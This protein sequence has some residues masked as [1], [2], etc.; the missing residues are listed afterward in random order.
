VIPQSPVRR[1]PAQTAQPLQD[2]RARLYQAWL[3]QHPVPAPTD[4][5]ALPLKLRTTDRLPFHAPHLVDMLLA[6]NRSGSQIRSTL[7]LGLQRTLERHVARYVRQ[8]RRVGIDNAAAMLVNYRTMEVKAVAGS[9]D[10][11]DRRIEG[12][13]NGTQA[14]RSPGSTLK[15]FIYALAMDQG[16]LHPMTVLK[17]A[18]TAFGPFSPENFDGRFLGPITARDA[19]IRSRNVPAVS[20][21]ARLSGPSFYEFLRSAGISRLAPEQ[22]YGLALVLGGGEVSMEELAM[23]YAALGNRGVLRPLRYRQSDPMPAG[24][25]VLSEEASFMTLDMLKAN[26]R[27][28]QA[29]AAQPGALRVYWKTGTSWGFRDAWTVGI[30][31]PYVLAVWIGNFNGESNPAFVGIQ[32]AAPL[33]FEIADSIRAQEPDLYEPAHRV[34]PNLARVEVCAASGDL[35]NTYCPARTQTWFIPG[36]S[37]IRMSDVHRAVIIDNRTGQQ[38][39]PPYDRAGVHVEVYEFWPSDMLRLF[40]QAGMP[41][42]VPPPAPENCASA[43]WAGGSAPRILSPLRGTTYTLRTRSLASETIALQASADADAEQV[44]WFVNDRFI[45]RAK[46]GST[47]LWAPGAPGSYVVRAVDGRGRSDARDLT[48]AVV[49]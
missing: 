29:F 33:F 34:P 17:D 32:A 36:K 9:V 49:Q 45:A 27:P 43:P 44:F 16:L 37:P 38:A 39:C 40:Q 22:H 14:K 46:S 31:G 20:V 30:F 1:A 19:L 2:A 8:Q 5:M 47:Y 42:R 41:R 48:I 21:A 18:P 7:D 25:R 35:P 28:D 3:A 15:P 24:I 26:P 13:V 6:E 11:F 12:Q 23:L 4:Y 10:F